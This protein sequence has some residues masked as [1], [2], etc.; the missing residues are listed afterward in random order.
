MPRPDYRSLMAATDRLYAAALDRSQWP[1][2]LSSLA[3]MFGADNA[4]VCR[5]DDRRGPS[6]YVSINPFKRDVLPVER[7]ASFM[8]DDPRMPVFNATYGRAMHCRM[9]ASQSRL[10]GS[11]AYRGYLNPLNI[12]YTMIAN[13]RRQDG[14]KD[15]IGLTRGRAGKAFDADDCELLNA[16]VPHLERSFTITRA[17]TDPARASPLPPASKP[18]QPDCATVQRML[19]L[20]PAQARVA[21]M[22][23]NG[24]SVK[25]AAAELGIAEGSARQY[26]K[27]IFSK[28]GARRQSELVRMMCDSL[29]LHGG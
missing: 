1:D 3:S 24:R 14:F 23:F 22:L 2:F 7:F 26:L 8:A 25:E 21:V 27:Q 9:V 10:H 11:R 4:F 15:G 18:P 16:L 29:L 5:F 19:A 12:E 20:P 28:T 13:F 6:D 17:L